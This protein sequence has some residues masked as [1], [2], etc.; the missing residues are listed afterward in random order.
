MASLGLVCRA[1]RE[2]LSDRLPPSALAALECT[3]AELK[4]T[5]RDN[6]LWRV[7]TV[8]DAWG[9][10]EMEL[11]GN[12]VREKGVHKI[13]VDR[14][15]LDVTDLTRLWT[16]LQGVETA[17]HISGSVKRVNL[18]RVM[19]YSEEPYPWSE[20]LSEPCLTLNALTCKF[21]ARSCSLL[22]FIGR[23]F[24]EALV[25]IEGFGDVLSSQRLIE[26]EA[27]VIRCGDLF[28][29]DLGEWMSPADVLRAVNNAMLSA[30]VKRVRL[31]TFSDIRSTPLDQVV[32]LTAEQWKTHGSRRTAEV[33]VIVGSWWDEGCQWEV[34]R[35]NIT[36]F[37]TR[38]HEWTVCKGGPPS[39]PSEDV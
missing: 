15:S 19:A 14:D 32:Q 31:G 7:L 8:T 26:V 16:A 30:G 21:D 5:I 37:E 34:W 23:R 4:S 25:V 22:E 6:G 28:P 3:S 24:P 27:G 20:S 13:Y 38:W 2:G 35:K 36:S 12:I 18:G 29:V 11:L 1:L 39:P 33:E 9:R 10:N 17:L